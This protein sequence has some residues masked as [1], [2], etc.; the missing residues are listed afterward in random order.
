M[1]FRR[2][3]C[4]LTPMQKVSRMNAETVKGTPCAC[5]SEEADSRF[6]E[7]SHRYQQISGI[8]PSNG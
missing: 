3:Y 5:L 4:S 1:K 7:S 6:V 8:W 2:E